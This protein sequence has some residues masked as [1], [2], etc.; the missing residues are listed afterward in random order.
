MQEAQEVRARELERAAEDSQA[1]ARTRA[2]LLEIAVRSAVEVR[3]TPFRAGD[4]RARQ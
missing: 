2:Q 1:D 3:P 4:A